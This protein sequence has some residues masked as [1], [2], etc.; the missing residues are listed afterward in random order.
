VSYVDARHQEVSESRHLIVWFR[1]A[2]KPECIGL[3][4]IF[5]GRDWLWLG[6]ILAPIAHL[7]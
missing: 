7:T 5:K 4:R 1:V 6:M 3:I 2:K